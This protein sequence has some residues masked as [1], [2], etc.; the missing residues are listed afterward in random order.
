MIDSQETVFAAQPDTWLTVRGAYKNYATRNH[1]VRAL[2]GVDLTI[3]RGSFSAIL[4]PSGCGKSTLLK[5]I[6]GIERQDEGHVSLAGRHLSGGGVHLPSERRD[7]G[8]VPQEG[9]LFPHLNVASNIGFGLNSWR[10]NPLSRS[11]RKAR[12]ERIEEMLELIGLA[13]HAKRRPD[14]LSGGQQQR[15]ALARAL[16]PSPK[17]ILLD[18]PFSALDAG[19]RAELR[20]EVRDLLRRTGTTSILVTHDQEEALSLADQVAIMRDGQVVQSGS[21]Q[22]IYTRP[23]D[24]GIA[25]FVGDAVLLP[26]VLGEAVDGIAVCE[27]GNI[28]VCSSCK[29]LGRGP[30]TLMLRPEQVVLDA[31]GLPARVHDFTFYGHDAVLTLGMGEDGSGSLVTVRVPKGNVPMPGDRV[32]VRVSGNAIAY[33]DGARPATSSVPRQVSSVF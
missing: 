15:I 30:C 12:A 25:S 19:L 23:A 22:E 20:M 8:I 28:S 29:W 24:P 32:Q 9:A 16:A 26:A 31:E 21:P 6:A 11:A 2:R 13:D 14:E 17:L 33:A 27:L 4:G 5:I 7:I 3:P 18:E 10:S 1:S